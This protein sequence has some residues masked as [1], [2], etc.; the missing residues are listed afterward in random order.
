MVEGAGNERIYRLLERLVQVSEEVLSYTRLQGL[1]AVR[2]ILEQEL[3]SQTDRKVYQES[4]ND[5]SVREV[6][7]ITNT[8][9]DFV[10]RRW[11]DWQKKGLMR[12]SLTQ[13]GR[14]ERAFDLEALGL[15]TEIRG[16]TAETE[17]NG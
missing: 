4:T 10:H 15:W 11:Q 6:A 13:K 8:K 9:K 16:E 14:F 17:S 2:G 12:P 1:S 3:P 7:I 5:R